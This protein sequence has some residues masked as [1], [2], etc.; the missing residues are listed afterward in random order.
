MNLT[1]WKGQGK[2]IVEFFQMIV[3]FKIRAKI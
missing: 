3:D 2:S 1:Q